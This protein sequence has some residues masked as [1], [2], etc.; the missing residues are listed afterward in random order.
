MP[1]RRHHSQSSSSQLNTTEHSLGHSYWQRNHGGESLSLSSQDVHRLVS[2]SHEL[3]KLLEEEKERQIRQEMAKEEELAV[4]EG[5]WTRFVLRDINQIPHFLRDN[6]YILTGYRV[7]YSYLDNF[8]SI[9]MW[10]NETGNIW[11]HMVPF[12]GFIAFM[13]YHLQRYRPSSS[14]LYLMWYLACCL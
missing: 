4:Q 1:R 12:F 2:S 6:D 5:R 10:H 7:Y 8:R 11:T 3:H 13:T 14:S 9:F